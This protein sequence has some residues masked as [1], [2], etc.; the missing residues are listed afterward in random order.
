MANGNIGVNEGTAKQT[1]TYTFTE[2]TVTKQ[3]ARIVLSSGTGAEITSWPVTGT[4]TANAGTGTFTIQSNAS[5]NFN[6]LGGTAVNVNTGNAG[7]GTQRVV[8]ATDQPPVA[9]TVGNAVGSGV[10]IRPGTGI[11]LD[12]SNIAGTVNLGTLNGAALETTQ[13]K[14]PINQGATATG[15]AGPMVQGV[16]STSAPSLT[17]GQVS[18]LSLT[19]SGD[20]RVTFTN[21]TVANTSSTQLHVKAGDSQAATI[22]H[23][24]RLTDGSGFYVAGGGSSAGVQYAEAA[25]AATVTGTA[26]MWKDASDTLR[27]VSATKPLPVNQQKLATPNNAG[28]GVSV[29][30]TSTVVAAANSARLEIHITNDSDTV[31]YLRLGTSAVLNS[32]IRLNAN[33]GSFTTDKY[34]GQI[35]AISSA[36]SKNLTVAEV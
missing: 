4:V 29:G 18:P 10:Y 24:V 17:A 21:A 3:L 2:D 19:P 5:I 33:G 34:T 14:I 6:Q 35:N 27:A 30:T 25:T 22:Y 9:T 8:I 32:G 28:S 26:V 20:Q 16:V 1:A 23:N 13:A 11:N 36:A 12:T 31:I 7:L 15:Q